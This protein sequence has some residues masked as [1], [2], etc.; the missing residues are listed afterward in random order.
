MMTKIWTGIIVLGVMAMLPLP[1][2]AAI[3]FQMMPI[4]RTTQYTDVIVLEVDGGPAG[5]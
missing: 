5:I 3:C 2:I 4:S 1:A